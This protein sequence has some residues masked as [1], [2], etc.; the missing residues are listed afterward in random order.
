MIIVFPIKV[1]KLDT[2]LPLPFFG[3][4][5]CVHVPEIISKLNNNKNCQLEQDDDQFLY[6]AIDG[7][8]C[9]N[10]NMVTSCQNNVVH[11]LM[12]SSD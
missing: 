6:S 2:C 5:C 1:M 9:H 12:Y 11:V 10:K 7:R 4:F 8:Q 3:I